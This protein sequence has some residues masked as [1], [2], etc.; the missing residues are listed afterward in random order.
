MTTLPPLQYQIGADSVTVTY[1]METSASGQ[2]VIGVSVRHD[3]H[4]V[5]Q[6]VHPA[7]QPLVFQEPRDVGGHM[8]VI[9][10]SLVR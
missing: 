7:S 6:E 9:I 8:F 10:R 5:T 2:G 1:H 3:V 4:A